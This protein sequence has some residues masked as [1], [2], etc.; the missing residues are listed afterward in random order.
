MG[1]LLQGHSQLNSAT[2]HPE[3]WGPSASD[4]LLDRIETSI[5]SGRQITF[6]GSDREASEPTSDDR[7]LG[8]TQIFQPPSPIP[9]PL[10]PKSVVDQY[11]QRYFTTTHRLYPILEER[12]FWIQYSQFWME[13]T[14]KNN[15]S[16]LALLYI[17]LALGHQLAATDTNSQQDQD[18]DPNDHGSM[19]FTL[20]KS[21]IAD[22]FFAGGDI[23]AVHCMFLA[24]RNIYS[25]LDILLI[26]TQYVWL[27]N[28]QRLHEAYLM[29]G[30]STRTAYGI[31]LHSESTS[32][33]LSQEESAS[34]IAT[35]WYVKFTSHLLNF[36]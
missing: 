25:E 15:C 27:Y 16:W 30:A 10:P 31:G 28:E 2:L 17:I 20:A 9:R 21:T 19:Y 6:Q 7:L 32:S 34:R 36:H 26:S 13:S 23:F 22:G 5:M 3:F 24:V 29:L 8:D 18:H 35:W 33:N 1:P 11:V 12:A 4:A 14:Q